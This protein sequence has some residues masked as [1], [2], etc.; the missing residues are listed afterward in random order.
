MDPVLHLLR[1]LIAIE[2]VNPSLVPGGAGEADV[3]ERVASALRHGGL[4]V[5]MAE[6]AP[7]RPNVV[8]VL[9]GRQPGRSLLFCGHTDTV[10]VEGMPA[11][12]DPVERAGRLYGRGSQ[13]MKSGVAAMVHAA[14]LV[15][16]QGGLA[17]GRLVVAAVVDEEHASIGAEALVAD[18][19]A[20][21][22]VVTEPT[23]LRVATGHKGFE[24]VEVETRGQA[25]HGSRPA[26]GRD[27]VLHMGRVLSGLEQV[28]T[29]LAAAP[30]DP[31]LG[32]ASLHASTIAGG[33]ELSVYPDHCRLQ[34]ERRT[35]P[36]ESD[37]VGLEE[38]RAVLDELA[39]T[40]TEFDG[41]ARSLLSRP[42]YLV[43]S[44]APVCRTLLDIWSARGGDR[45]TIG[46]SYWTDAAILSRAGTPSVLFGPSG[47]GLHG[48][49]EFVETDSV[50]T[51]RDVL[52]ELA[53]DF[54]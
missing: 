20:D 38:A 12:F 44:D 25:A 24:W 16:Q 54:C 9:E 30:P 10:G 33:R 42:A 6:V 14:T 28:N 1:D 50:I 43:D 52:I 48:V 21:G 7:G 18:R 39:R 47:A 49:E 32:T 11:P 46:M 22:A 51:C 27:A 2:S 29:R 8:G 23:A 35:L 5:E 31:M 41:T 36:G 3:A 34:F 15:A 19:V 26:D 4:D 40:D 13:D 17:T 37:T 45:T 53:R